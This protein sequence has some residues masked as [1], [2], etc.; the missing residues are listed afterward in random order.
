MSDDLV[1]SMSY[2][3][4]AYRTVED[5]KR[6]EEAAKE[7]RKPPTMLVTISADPEKAR[8]QLRRFGRKMDEVGKAMKK[9]GM[10][11]K[12]A[13]E[14]MGRMFTPHSKRVRRFRQ[15]KWERRY[16]RVGNPVPK[17]KRKHGRPRGR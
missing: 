7:R 11:A 14:S 2:A 9:M 10:S 16:G 8:S 5:Q 17:K 4:S 6:I 1:D 15:K 12:D 13:A 3:I